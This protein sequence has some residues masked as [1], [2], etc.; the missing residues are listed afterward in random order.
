MSH[1][2]R[3]ITQLN[4]T[5]DSDGLELNFADEKLLSTATQDDSVEVIQ[6][7]IAGKLPVSFRYERPDGRIAR[8]RVVYPKEV[9]D[10]WHFTFMRAYCHFTPDSRVFRIDRIRSIRIARSLPDI[11]DRHQLIMLVALVLLIAVFT[12]LFVLS[13]TYH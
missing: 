1:P 5:P 13:P 12:S 4:Y 9:F 11:L 10:K 7:A 8:H 2:S 3:E 6:A